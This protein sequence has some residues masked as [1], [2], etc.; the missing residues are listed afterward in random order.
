M[1]DCVFQQRTHNFGKDLSFDGAHFRIFAHYRMISGRA[2]ELSSFREA[3]TRDTYNNMQF[4]EAELSRVGMNIFFLE[5]LM[6][7]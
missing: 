5:L 2:A 3:P 1:T 6:E 7:D 4:S